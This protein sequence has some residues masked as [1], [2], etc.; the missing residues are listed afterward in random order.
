MLIFGVIG[1]LNRKLNLEGAPFILALV[2]GPL[3]EKSL[4]QSLLISRGDI[5]IFFS[6]PISIVLIGLGI[7]SIL[8]SILSAKTR[9]KHLGAEG[10]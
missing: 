6:R 8:F 4:R 9:E 1:Y 10:D 3:M 7:A 5:G 2:L